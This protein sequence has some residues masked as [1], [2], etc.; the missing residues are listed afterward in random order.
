MQF[1]INLH[2]TMFFALVVAGT[3]C[4]IWGLALFIARNQAMKKAAPEG[5]S[6]SEQQDAAGN[7][8]AATETPAQP[9]QPLINPIF[10]SAL[11]V[12]AGLALLQAIIGA[13]LF[14]I[15]NR[16]PDQLHY[17]YGLVV[18]FAI[19]AA[20]IYL[21]GKPE[22]IRRDLLMLAFAALVVAAAAVRA[23]LTGGFQ[24]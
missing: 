14:L 24:F 16:P 11:R 5:A 8:P 2:I 20:L 4:T 22:H 7:T 19:P 10:S 3:I 12:T 15:G 23:A 21:S 1:L 13:A 6:A 17:V 9:R 18:L